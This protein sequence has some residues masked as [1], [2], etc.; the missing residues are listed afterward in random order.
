MAKVLALLP[1]MV[2]GLKN[3]DG[4]LVVEAVQDLK[5]IFKEQGKKLKDNSVYEEILQ[6]LLPHFSDVRHWEGLG[7]EDGERRVSHCLGL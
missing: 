2:N 6:I 4:V 1:S 3:M 7:K 5:T